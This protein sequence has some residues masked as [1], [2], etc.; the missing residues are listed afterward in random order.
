MRLFAREAMTAILLVAGL[1]FAAAA[2]P[3]P[4]MDSDGVPDALTSAS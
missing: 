3:P 1:P 2:G 4:D